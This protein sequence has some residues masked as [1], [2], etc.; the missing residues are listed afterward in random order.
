MNLSILIIHHWITIPELWSLDT[1]ALI[2]ISNSLVTV[3]I[4]ALFGWSHFPS[5][6]WLLTAPQNTRIWLWCSVTDLAFLWL[7]NDLSSHWSETFYHPFLIT[8]HLNLILGFW[9]Q[10]VDFWSLV[11]IFYNDLIFDFHFDTSSLIWSLLFGLWC[12]K[13]LS[14]LGASS[15]PEQ[16]HN[17]TQNCQ[18]LNILRMWELSPFV[19]AFLFKSFFFILTKN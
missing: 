4:S 17:I 13:L 7:I 6:Y 1:D 16:Y 10:S 19:Q 8:P 15:C 12:F 11:V 3:D 5:A 18:F 2:L 9:S 14:T